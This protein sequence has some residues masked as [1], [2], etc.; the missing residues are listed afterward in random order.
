MTEIAPDGRE[1]FASVEAE[2]QVLASILV[3]NANFH[4]IAEQITAADFATP[5]HGRLFATI[6][7]MIDSGVAATPIT[8]GARFDG[9]PDFVATGGRRYLVRLLAN[10]ISTGAIRDYADLVLDAKLRRDLAAA[11]RDAD[12]AIGDPAIGAGAAAARLEEVAGTVSA[13]SARKALY[14]THISAV[15]TAVD[16]MNAAFSD[17]ESI[18]ISTGV[19][20]LDRKLNGGFRAGQ[21]IVIAGR[22]A[23][24]KSTT[25]HNIALH[26]SRV[27]PGRPPRPTFYGTLEMEAW[28]L[29]QRGISRNLRETGGPRIPYNL[30]TSGEIGKSQF[31][32]V[33]EEASRQRAIPI[34]YGEREV[35]DLRRFRSAVLRYAAECRESGFPLSL[36]VLDYV[37]RMFVR[38][39]KEGKETINRCTD[40]LKALAQELGVPVVLLSQLNREVERRD[41]PIPQ[42][43]D[44]KESGSLEED[45]DV[46]I[47][48]YR[49]EYYS[50]QKIGQAKNERDRLDAEA[51]YYAHRG[52]VQYIVAKQRAGSTGMITAFHDLPCNLISSDRASDPE[53][54]V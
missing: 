21:L 7:E 17:D 6:V 42:L 34:V 15:T 28:E 29:A 44:L 37:Q 36:V 24:G 9:D 23:M 39:V 35:K 13:R 54:L 2:Q 50:V 31:S 1:T 22:P 49:P 33:V 32:A 5:L 12:A 3:E 14:S 38:G 16:R 4:K 10:S 41:P 45:A 11:M 48:T 47:F 43:A 25:A 40:E 53:A 8:L 27:E 30:L 52:Q 19:R 46:V 20:Q 51:D 26:N 18:A